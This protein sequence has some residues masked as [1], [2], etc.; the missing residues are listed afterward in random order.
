MNW[1]FTVVRPDGLVYLVCVVPES[2]FADYRQA[3][4]SVL[5]S[6]QFQ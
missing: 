4:E 2:E 5:K 6:V 3:F 1:L